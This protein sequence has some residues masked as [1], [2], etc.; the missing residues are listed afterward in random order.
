MPLAKQ[1]SSG[2]L[3][4]L[5]ET[6]WKSMFSPSWPWLSP[7]PLAPS[8]SRP[9]CLRLSS[10]SGPSVPP[11]IPI[12]MQTTS[13]VPEWCLL[14]SPKTVPSLLAHLL[15]AA[16]FPKPSPLRTLLTGCPSLRNHRIFTCMW[17][18][19]FQP[20]SIT[21]LWYLPLTPVHSSQI[22]ALG[23]PQ[24]PHPLQLLTSF[25]MTSGTLCTIHPK[26]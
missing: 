7:C 16:Y 8:Q 22:L 24:R 25:R 26:D 23:H 9:S 5:L 17:K 14:G 13:P 21:A 3:L 10:P 11:R 2:F 4:F 6:F 20:F 19:L 12:L 1:H 15:A 18:C